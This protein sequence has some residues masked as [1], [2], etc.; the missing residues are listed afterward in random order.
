[1]ADKVP[2]PMWQALNDLNN[3]VQ[4][5]LATVAGALKDA[6]KRMAGGKGD[7][8]VGPT[9]RAWGSQLSGASTD[10]SRQANQ[11]ADYVRGQLA[12]QQKEVTPQQADT[13][14]RILAGRLR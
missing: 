1:M 5:E 10:I 14:R 13:E 11:F 8:W 3:S 2:S 9:A 4:R 7:A 12:A 6:D